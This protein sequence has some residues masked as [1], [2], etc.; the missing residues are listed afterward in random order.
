MKNIKTLD[1]PFSVAMGNESS[2]LTDCQIDETPILKN[3]SDFSLHHAQMNVDMSQ[4]TVFISND[5]VGD[6]KNLLEMMGKVN[7]YLL[8]I[9]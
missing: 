2:V 7:I 5:Q 8:I 9:F 6:K 4:L 1:W 3:G